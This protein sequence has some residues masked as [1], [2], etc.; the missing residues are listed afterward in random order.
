[1]DASVLELVK[2]EEG[3][4]LQPYRDTKGVLTIGYGT[5]IENI[6]EGEAEWLLFNR[7]DDAE[8][9]VMVVINASTYLMQN[10]ARR[11]VLI[12]MAY[13]LGRSR[14]RTFK[15]MILALQ[16]NDHREAAD[17]MLDSKWAKVDVPDRARR[18]A[19]IMRT[20]RF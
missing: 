4:R 20:G 12:S 9:D 3:L 8:V 5:N 17:Q 2:Q 18:A 15:K 19:D 14:L 11:A 16:Q 1:M 10:E 13:N 6:D 7:L